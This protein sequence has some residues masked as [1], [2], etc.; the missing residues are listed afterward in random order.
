LLKKTKRLADFAK[1]KI[2]KRRGLE[3][4]LR[5]D[6]SY[7]REWKHPVAHLLQDQEN[8]GRHSRAVRVLSA[9]NQEK[10]RVVGAKKKTDAVVGPCCSLVS[11]WQVG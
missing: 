10:A 8:K 3:L 1:G 6:V 11:V 7:G 9:Q 4:N 5:K 2:K